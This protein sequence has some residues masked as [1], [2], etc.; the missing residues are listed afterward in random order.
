VSEGV[1]KYVTDKF[2][3]V[4]DKLGSVTVY[5]HTHDTHSESA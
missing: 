3:Y 5:I 2:K 4:T 1:L